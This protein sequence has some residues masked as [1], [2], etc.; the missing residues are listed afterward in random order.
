VV[1]AGISEHRKRICAGSHNICIVWQALG[2]D[3]FFTK[4]VGSH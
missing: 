3:K 4:F 2:S 1:E